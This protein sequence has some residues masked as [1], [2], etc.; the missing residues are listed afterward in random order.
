MKRDRSLLVNNYILI[1][2]IPSARPQELV[3]C[4]F[5]RFDVYG[6]CI[7]D[8]SSPVHFPILHLGKYL[9][10]LTQLNIHQP[11]DNN[12][13]L[14]NTTVSIVKY[15]V[16]LVIADLLDFGFSGSHLRKT[17]LSLVHLLFFPFPSKILLFSK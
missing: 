14:F 4:R 7:S 5:W 6:I 10:L 8:I 17:E 13:N 11:R 2:S 16:S 9:F 12:E 1:L 3:K 15:E